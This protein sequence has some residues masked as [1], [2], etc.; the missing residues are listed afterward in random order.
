[1]RAIRAKFP[2][3]KITSGLSN[4]SFGL[5]L[6]KLIN[7]NFLCLAMYEGMDSAILDPA[8]KDIRGTLLAV[9]MLTAKDKNCRKFT[10][11]FRKGE[12]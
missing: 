1:M 12:L 2:G 4:I 3:V 9:D 10:T 11:A 8:D 7:R 6:R 5:P